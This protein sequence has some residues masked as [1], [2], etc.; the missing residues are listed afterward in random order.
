VV[1]RIQINITEVFGHHE[2]IKEVVDL[3][4][5]VHVSYYDFI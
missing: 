2:M 5:Q 3:S 1:S 4:K